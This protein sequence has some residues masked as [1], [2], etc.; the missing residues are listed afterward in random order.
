MDT[1][2]TEMK[3]NKMGTMPVKKLLFSMAIPMIA[4]ML[5][6]ALYNIVDS[7]FVAKL[8]EDALSAVSLAFPMQNLMIAVATGTGVG[9]NALLSKNLGARRFEGAN[10]AANISLFLAV[11]NWIIF[12]F[13]GLFVS[14]IYLRGQTSNAAIISQG[15]TYLKICLVGSFGLFGQVTFERLLQATGR[16]VLS[17]ISQLV[18]AIIN[19]ILDPILIFGLLGAPAMGVAGAALAT[20]IGQFCGMFLG[21]YLCVTKNDE[22]KLRIKDALPTVAYL[23]QI[24]FVAIPSILMV[25]IGSIMVFGMNRIL[26]GYTKTAL[27]VFGSYFK[28]QSFIFMPVFGINNAMIPI[29]AYNYGARKRER[30]LETMK[31]SAITA[32]CIMIVGFAIFQIFPDKLLRIFDASDYMLEIGVP[33]LRI[34]SFSFILAGFN[35]VT[36]AVFQ[37]LGNGLYSLTVSICRQL[38]ALLP[39]A[40][41]ISIVFKD[42]SKIWFAF[43]LA[44]LIAVIL[45]FIFFNKLK[46]K[47]LNFG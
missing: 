36:G 8:S 13:V 25:S 18:G 20:I 31:T 16:T 47:K 45:T 21:M 5:V 17:M 23:K 11:I 26:D 14:G 6:Q 42:L 38:L 33:A 46:S 40:L 4:S 3:E 7:A 29:I 1:I 32:T 39:I 12:I 43:P 9:V 24:Y 37:A 44:E 22:I 27:A 19:I 34:I 41:V 15:E 2:A 35:I 30:I 28:L 10:K